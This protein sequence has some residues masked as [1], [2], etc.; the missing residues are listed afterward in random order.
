LGERKGKKSVN[1]IVRQVAGKTY[2]E[3][4][5]EIVV[6]SLEDGPH[7]KQFAASRQLV[8]DEFDCF[9]NVLILELLPNSAF[10]HLLVQVQEESYLLRR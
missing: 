8:T 4:F 9:V 10:G 3:N 2:L 1:E 7:T 6:V 5:V